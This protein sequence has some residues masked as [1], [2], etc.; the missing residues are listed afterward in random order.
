MKSPKSSQFG[1]TLVEMI[2]SLALFSVVLTISVGALLMLIA[3]NQQLQAE[4]SV[5]TNLSFALD[6]MAREIRTGTHYYC[7]SRAN[8][9]AGGGDA[10]FDTSTDQE[11]VNKTT[12]DCPDGNDIS[13]RKLQGVSFREGGES[14]TTGIGE[15]ILYF[16]DNTGGSDSGKILR[17][18]GNDDPQ[19]IVSSGIYIENAEFFVS[20]SS[21]GTGVGENQ[22]A[23]TIFI[24]AREKV[25]ADRTYQIQTT[26]V[27]RTLD[28]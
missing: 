1:F 2:V 17:R 16:Y 12:Q 25:G 27:Q 10:I 26:I 24:E 8:Y 21:P 18:V 7:A 28:I 15:R 11:G 3:T 23:V 19:S 14:V 13:G 9:N 4:Q 5:M 6:S 22:A 20:G